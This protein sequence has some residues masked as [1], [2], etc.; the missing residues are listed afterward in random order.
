[1]STSPSVPELGNIGAEID[2]VHV[3]VGPRFLDLFSKNLY[4][5]PNKAFEELVSNSWDAGAT[6]VHIGI[7][8]NLKASD[9]TVWILDN[10]ESMDASGLKQLW[11]IADS[12][13]PGR[14]HG[15]SQIGKFGIGKLATYLLARRLTYVCRAADGVIRAVEMDYAAIEAAGTKSDEIEGGANL[16]AGTDVSRPLR[17]LTDEDLD[18]LL[19]RIPQGSEIRRLILSGLKTAA[20]DDPYTDEFG[21]A[22]TPPATAAGTWTLAIMTDLK[23][24]GQSMQV[25]WIRWI[26]RTALPLGNSMSMFFNGERLT[27]SKIDKPIA[28]DIILG[29]NFPLDTIEFIP[30][31]SQPSV[32]EQ[33]AVTA[34]SSPIPHITVDGI[35]GRITGSAKR[36]KTSISGKK[37]DDLERSNGFFVNVLGRVVNPEDPYFGLENL[38]HSVWSEF[39]MTVRADGL[40][41]AIG[42]NREQ[43]NETADLRIF[44]AL[45]RSVFN[46]ARREA[47][48]PENSAWEHAGVAIAKSWGAIPLRSFQRAMRRYE[49]EG[50]FPPSIILIDRADESRVT[51]QLDE[52]ESQA[53]GDP[54]SIVSAVEF[55]RLGGLEQL[56]AYDVARRVIVVNTDHP[57]V[58]MHGKTEAEK[59]VL[60]SLAVAETLSSARLTDIGVAEPLI[61]DYQKYRDQLYRMV[62]NIQRESGVIIAEQLMSSTAEE[63]ALEIIVGDA[64]EYIGF[65]VNRLGDA[66]DPEGLATSP[67]PSSTINPDRPYKFTYDAK[68]TKH[69]SVKTK[70]LNVAVLDHHRKKYSAQYSLV[71][72]PNFQEGQLATLCGRTRVIPMRAADLARIL[73]LAAGTGPLDLRNFETLFDRSSPDDVGHWVDELIEETLS[74]GRLSLGDVLNVIEQIDYASGEPISAQFI[75]EELRRLGL[76]KQ[77]FTRV[78][79]RRLFEG[80]AVLVPS[81]VSVHNDDIYLGT[82]PAKFRDA[83]IQQVSVIPAEFRFGLEELQRKTQA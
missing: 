12:K 22:D 82:S 66:G 46:V 56:Y 75:S 9:A 33:R 64:L 41:H 79:V 57:F 74:H 17:K 8:S 34:H 21:E 69:A 1:M 24:L 62:T 15:R 7:P 49:R 11:R 60:R 39:R 14:T 25:G 45:L 72:A 71:V 18:V 27:S 68:S 35:P 76:V 31:P 47:D 26:L 10:G 19:S 80:L 50:S 6:D 51:E 38:N 48:S 28:Q 43:L 23:D 20:A 81:L 5:S 30:D 2:Q 77:K 65:D 53:E 55:E 42:I 3:I 70:D 16:L 29:P 83:I 44:R 61:E 73:L 63:R 54:G 37:S 4:R 67:S 36:Y 52:W 32:V 59:R 13:K 40:N 58:R 78:Q